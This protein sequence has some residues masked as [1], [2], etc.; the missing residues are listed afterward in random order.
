[1]ARPTRSDAALTILRS[2][3]LRPDDVAANEVVTWNDLTH[4]I[5]ASGRWRHVFRYPSLELITRNVD[6]LHRPLV[7]SVLLRLL[8]RGRVAIVDE[9]GGRRR[10]GWGRLLANGVRALRDRR[11]SAALVERVSARVDALAAEIADP[12]PA[13]STLSR[14]GRPL[15][16]RTDL[17]FGVSSGG[18]VGHIAGVVNHLGEFVGPPVFATTDRIP[19]VRDDVETHLLTPPA[20]W[21]DFAEPLILACNETFVAQ[22]D[23][24]APADLAF[25]YQRYSTHSFAGL[26][27]ARRRRVPFVLEFNGSERW[28]ARQWSGEPLVY[29][30]LAGRIERLNLAG[31]DLVVAVSEA[32]GEQAIECGAS[33]ER[34]L[35]NPNGVDTDRFHP[36]VDG[37][38]VRER[39]GLGD[40]SVIGFIGT[41]G[42]WHGIEVL[43]EAYARW[44]ERDPEARKQTCL[45]LIGAGPLLPGVLEGFDRRGLLENVH[46]VGAVPQEE[47][48]RWLAACDVLV[49]PHVPNADGTRFFGSPTKLFE[50]MAMGRPIVASRLEQIGEVLDHERTALLVPPGDVDALV[51]AMAR[52]AADEALRRR[53]GAAAREVAETRHTWRRHTERI[54]TALGEQLESAAAGCPATASQEPV[55]G[56]AT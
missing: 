3:V 31:A 13:R 50:Y 20:R 19:T 30:E 46:S 51:A 25:V 32:A 41:F 39:L 15:H 56:P 12:G 2:T 4:A 26:E 47:A 38:G 52:L 29:D 49:S 33:R 18:S 8:A 1:M 42:P 37:Q 43:A 11:D 21:W 14:T 53:L 22:L 24:I 35:V 28:V 7:T 54:V 45:L 27:L 9:A 44:L 55:N 40:R 36:E 48:P 6:R 23:A 10:V 17:V 5:K 34:L 16:L